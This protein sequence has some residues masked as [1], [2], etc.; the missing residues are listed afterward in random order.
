MIFFGFLRWQFSKI[1]FPFIVKEILKCYHS[2]G[3]VR[4]S[5]FLF[6]LRLTSKVTFLLLVDSNLTLYCT[7][8]SETLKA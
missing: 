2:F 1:F 3:Q 8:L 5:S 6:E 7:V 4:A